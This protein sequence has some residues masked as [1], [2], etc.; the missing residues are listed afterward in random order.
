MDDAIVADPSQLVLINPAKK[1]G[2][3]VGIKVISWGPDI[4]PKDRLESAKW[5]A[6]RALHSTSFLKLIVPSGQNF[7]GAAR[8]SSQ[9]GMGTTYFSLAHKKAL[10]QIDYGPQAL[11]DATLHPLLFTSPES[12][13]PTRARSKRRGFFS[14]GELIFRKSCPRSPRTSITVPWT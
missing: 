6:A 7:I 8:A 11:I 9:I 3:S 1:G 10:Q 2:F 4:H 5:I 13:R 14:D 12:L